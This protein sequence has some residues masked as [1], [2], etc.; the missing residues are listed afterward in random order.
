[1]KI[2]V[3][4]WILSYQEVV[5]VSSSNLIQIVKQAAVEAIEAKKPCDYTTGIVTSINP[6]KVKISQTLELRESFL[7]LTGTVTA[8]ALRVGEKVLLFRKSGGKRYVVIDRMVS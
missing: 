7:D 8:E 4:A 5:L 2:D 6:L 3:G 1:M